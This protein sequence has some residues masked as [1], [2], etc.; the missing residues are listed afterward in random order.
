MLIDLILSLALWWIFHF[1]MWKQ[2]L[3]PLPALTPIKCSTI[4]VLIASPRTSHCSN[5]FIVTTILFDA[6][7]MHH[8]MNWW[9]CSK[10]SLPPRSSDRF[11]DIYGH[12]RMTPPT[13][14]CLTS[15]LST[16]FTNTEWIGACVKTCRI[17]I[18]LMLSQAI[19]HWRIRWWSL[20]TPNES[21]R[22]PILTLIFV[23]V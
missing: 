4:W 16:S 3:Y 1:Y 22:A 2:R 9:S 10:K 17:K 5:T 14:L 7:N 20:L 8:H 21:V 15:W 13:H 6:P 18:E 23:Y 12:Q 19:D 11:N